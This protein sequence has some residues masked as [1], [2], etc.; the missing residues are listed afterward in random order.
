MP[1]REEAFGIVYCEACAFGLPPIATD[2]GGVG[3][4]IATGVN[5][6]LLPLEAGAE[7]YARAIAQIWRCDRRYSE[8][9]IAARK[10]FE[11]RLS[12]RAWGEALDRELERVVS[13]SRSPERPRDVAGRTAGV[14]RAAAA[15]RLA[16]S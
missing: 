12:W 11:T 13:L 2:T 16:T 14:R 3:E 9:Q 8:M 10:A 7:D 15:G 1:S 5:G 6:L 4:I